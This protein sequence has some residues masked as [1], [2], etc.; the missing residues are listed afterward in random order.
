MI[1]TTKVDKSYEC[2]TNGGSIE[3]GNARM[4]VLTMT[5]HSLIESKIVNNP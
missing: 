1:M 4:M 5:W 2:G 3:E